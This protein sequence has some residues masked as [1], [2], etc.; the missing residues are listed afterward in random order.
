MDPWKGPEQKD[1]RVGLCFNRIF[2]HV[3][4][5]EAA[6]G[7]DGSRGWLGYSSFNPDRR[8]GP[9]PGWLAVDMVKRLEL[10]SYF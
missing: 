10:C 4:A 8:I 2:C 1:D 9:G 3:G 7:R 5:G 6:R